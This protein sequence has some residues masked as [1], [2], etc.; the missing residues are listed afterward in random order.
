MKR[1]GNITCVGRLWRLADRNNQPEAHI[2]RARFSAGRA[3]RVHFVE[4]PA[5][6]VRGSGVSRPMLRSGHDKRVLPFSI[7]IGVDRVSP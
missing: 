2:C 5:C 1:T 7:P 6:Q 3:C 4:G